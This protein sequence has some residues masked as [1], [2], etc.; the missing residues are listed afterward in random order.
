M[1]SSGI[2]EE[3]LTDFTIAKIFGKVVPARSALSEDF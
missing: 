3:L 2:D 1:R